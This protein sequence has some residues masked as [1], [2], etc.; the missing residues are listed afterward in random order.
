M[1]ACIR[2]R[3]RQTR[4]FFEQCE[5]K[6][7]TVTSPIYYSCH[8]KLYFSNYLDERLVYKNRQKNVYIFIKS[9]KKTYLYIILLLLFV[10]FN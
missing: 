4:M 10:L 1:I 2:E 5:L 8:I 6:I 7:Y 9:K 3:E